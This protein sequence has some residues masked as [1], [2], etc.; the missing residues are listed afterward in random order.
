[1]FETA[2]QGDLS[3]LSEQMVARI[4]AGPVTKDSRS[5]THNPPRHIA[6]SASD[7]QSEPSAANVEDEEEND[8][9]FHMPDE[10]HVFSGEMEVP[11]ME[12]PAVYLED[13]DSMETA[14]GDGHVE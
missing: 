7:A 6:M 12:E 4:A 2:R 9:E 8:E 1:L 14:P 3:L 5:S 13:L 10:G 11:E